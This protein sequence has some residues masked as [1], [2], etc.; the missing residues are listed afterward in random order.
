MPSSKSMWTSETTCGWAQRS[1]GEKLGKVI[2]SFK[3]TKSKE[4]KIIENKIVSIGK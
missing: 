3:K 4:Y 1:T 2:H